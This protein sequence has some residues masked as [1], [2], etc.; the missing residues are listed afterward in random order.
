MP[1]YFL[2]ISY[3]GTHFSGF[4]KQI[5]GNPITVQDELEKALQML[6][7]APID[8]T[9][10]SRTDAG[11]HALQNFLHF[12][13]A[14]EIPSNLLYKMNAILPPTLQVRNIF[15]VPDD[16]HARFDATSRKY[17]YN[18]NLAKDPF[19]VE[20]AWYYP[21]KI[22]TSVL[23]I[24]AEIIKNNLDFSAFCKKNTQVYT[25]LCSIID[26]HWVQ[27]GSQVVY[28]VEA[29]RF[30]RGMVRGLVATQ[31]RVAF[32]KITIEQFQAILENK[33]LASAEFGAP[34]AGLFLEKV[35]Y[36]EDVFLE[37]LADSEVL[38]DFG[39]I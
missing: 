31:I 10:S 22:D 6:L 9:T 19:M 28:H 25:Y 16:K 1:R 3:Q 8:T 14:I 7:K 20:A 21:F 26:S 17:F 24:T 11:V 23:P 4:A 18:I 29:N 36:P 15:K 13:T 30:L 27:K 35:N 34:G 2:E 12:D 33:V 39:K 5:E 32:G 38:R 37:P